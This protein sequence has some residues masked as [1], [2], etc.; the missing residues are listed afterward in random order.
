MFALTLR[1]PSLL[2]TGWRVRCGYTHARAHTHTHT[3]AECPRWP[4]EASRC[5]E[6]NEEL[7]VYRAGSG[8]VCPDGR[9]ATWALCS[10]LA[11]RLAGSRS[12]T[13]RWVELLD[14]TD[15]GASEC[16]SLILCRLAECDP[17]PLGAAML[18]VDWPDGRTLGDWHL[19]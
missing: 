2:W 1:G 12:L 5:F 14:Y 18:H 4:W 11:S 19:G 17:M 8:S 6:Q 9:D 3:H 16:P 7:D 15:C 13:F 10:Q